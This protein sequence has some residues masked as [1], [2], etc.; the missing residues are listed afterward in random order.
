MREP[1]GRQPSRSQ[2]AADLW[3]QGDSNPWPSGRKPGFCVFLRGWKSPDGPFSCG[4]CRRLSVGVARSLAPLAL[5]L[6]LLR[7]SFWTRWRDSRR[8]NLTPTA[9]AQVA[10][11][12]FPA[13]SNQE[14][15]GQSTD[16][17]TLA[18]GLLFTKA[19]WLAPPEFT[20]TPAPRTRRSGPR[21]QGQP[22]PATHLVSHPSSYPAARAGMTH[23][24]ERNVRRWIKPRY[25]IGAGWWRCRARGRLHADCPVRVGVPGTERSLEIRH[26]RRQT[27]RCT[28][29]MRAGSGSFQVAKRSPKLRWRARPGACASPRAS[30]AAWPLGRRA[31]LGPALARVRCRS[32]SGHRGVRS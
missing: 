18:L 25:R 32:W 3:S 6:A 20:G 9:S 17:P 11:T 27:A 16:L 23:R 26:P 14:A 22:P 19:F 1:S 15:A 31:R 7:P 4:D 2:L 12:G 29:A 8:S 21:P 30:S 5:C 10:L 24:D 28:E 13:S